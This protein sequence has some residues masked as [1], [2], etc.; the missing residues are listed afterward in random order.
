MEAGPFNLGR[1]EVPVELAAVVAKMMAKEPRRRFH[2]PGEVAQ[3]LAPFFKPGANTGTGSR[4]AVAHVGQAPPAVVRDQP[5]APQ[6][7]NPRSEPVVGPAAPPRANPE[8]VAWAS[9]IEIK[10]DEQVTAPVKPNSVV[11]HVPWRRNR[12]LWP[13]V[14]AGVLLIG[15]FDSVIREKGTGVILLTDLGFGGYTSGMPRRARAIQ[16]GYVYHVLNRSNARATLFL[17]D[18][19]YAAFERALEEAFQRE[20]LRIL[21]YCVMP[22]HW[23]MVVW[24][25]AGKDNQVSDFFRWLTVTHTQRWHAHYRTAGSGHLYQGRFKSFP[26]ESDEHLYTVLRYVERNP[27]RSNLVERAQDWR[28]SS[29]GRWTQGDHQARRLLA[30]WPIARPENWVARVNRAEGRKELE[31]LRRS[32]QRGQPYG[33]EPWCERIVKRLGLESTLRPRGRPRKT[34]SEP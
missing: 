18:D 19:D 4:P 23:H 17:K 2:T 32:V 15:I 16:G 20:P 29:L 24:P 22:N 1:P 8:A 11:V 34:R 13:A 25:Q 3:A 6:P 14:A 30:A 9:L 5:A 33:S 10:E 28:W 7:A 21:G 26:V 27:L 12:S 31:A